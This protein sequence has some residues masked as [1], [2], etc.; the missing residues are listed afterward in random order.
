MRKYYATI[1]VAEDNPDDRQ[2]I[3]MG[4]RKIGVKGPIHLVCSGDEAIAYMKGEGRYSDRNQ[5]AYPSFVMTDLK[6]PRGDGFK[7]LAFLKRNPAIWPV[8]RKLRAM[9]GALR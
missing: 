8:V 4:F 1:L 9:V 6:M 5:F 3:E 2:F 7:V